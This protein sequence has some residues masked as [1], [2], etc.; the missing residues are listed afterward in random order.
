MK[1]IF[2]TILSLIGCFTVNAQAYVLP[3]P[4]DAQE[5]ITLYINVAGAGGKLGA[6]LAVHPDDNV[7]IWTWMP[8]DPVVQNG[9]WG[10]SNEALLMTKVSDMLYSISFIPT[11]FYTATGPEFFSR[12]IKC[13]AK[14][15]NGN[16]YPDLFGGEAKT[17]DLTI[18]ITP[19]LCDDM[20]CKFPAAT[21]A[22]DYLSITYDNNQETQV[23]LQN[24]GADDCYLFL[25]MEINENQFG[26]INYVAPAQTTSTAELKMNPVDG[27]PGFFRLSILPEDFF[28][29][30]LPSGQTI[31]SIR[32]YV[33]SGSF[34][35]PGLLPYDSYH[36]L[37]CQ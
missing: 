19:K 5:E 14:L 36:F 26:G 18:G 20:Y 11:E 4:T 1:S 8:S 32:Y 22:D 27:Q 15:N 6:M 16:E 29:D 7:Y 25:R 21:R 13:L 30:I 31:L 2:Y 12:G 23:E 35:H 37:T 10:D 17:D 28:A 24:L 34:T 33:L 3:S 9:T